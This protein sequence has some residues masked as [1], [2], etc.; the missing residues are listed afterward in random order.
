MMKKK[1]TIVTG[2]VLMSYKIACRA[3]EQQ[4]MEELDQRGL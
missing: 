3:G 2:L 4:Q 1:K